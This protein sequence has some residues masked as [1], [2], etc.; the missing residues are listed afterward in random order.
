MRSIGRRREPAP[1]RDERGVQSSMRSQLDLLIGDRR[2]LIFGLSVTSIVSGFTEAGTLA[3]VAQVAAELVG[4]ATPQ[5]AGLF[6]VHASVGTLLLIGFGLAIL[7]LALQMPLSILPARIAADVQFGCAA[8]I[9]SAFTRAS[10]DAQSRDREG[11]LQETM[12]SQTA[13]RRR[14]TAGD[15]ADHLVFD[16]PRADGLR[17]RAEPIRRGSRVR[18]RAGDV[19]GAAAA[20]ELSGPGAAENSRK[21]RSVCQRASPRPTG[22]PRRRRCSAWWPRRTRACA[23]C[24]AMYAISS[25]A[26]S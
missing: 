17:R 24:C 21:L 10:W 18:D 15:Q 1:A 5:K 6:H 7:R 2:R 9:F 8:K 3:I 11:L 13:R 12:T 23:A 4:K 25:T 14:G 16:I 19:R 22:S 26:R 20:C